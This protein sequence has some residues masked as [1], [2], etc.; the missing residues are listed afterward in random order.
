MLDLFDAVCSGW[1]TTC[2]HEWWMEK[3]ERRSQSPAGR[4]L[5][6]DPTSRRR[7][8]QRFITKATPSA[9]RERREMT[10]RITEWMTAG[11]ATLRLTKSTLSNVLGINSTHKQL[12]KLS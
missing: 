9:F 6:A 5:V 3:D 1:M 2:H 12:L 10:P 7:I 11:N 8:Y 4:K